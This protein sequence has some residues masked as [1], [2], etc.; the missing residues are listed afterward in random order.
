MIKSCS[1]L[2]D[3]TVVEADICII[4]GG[5]AGLTLAASLDG[6]PMRVAVIEAGG[7]PSAPLGLSESSVAAGQGNLEPPLRIPPR[8]GGGANE[9]IVRLANMQRGVRMLPLS[10][11][12]LESRPWIPHSGWPISWT[13]LDRYYRQANDFLGLSDRGYAAEDWE[14]ER[15]RRFALE[16]HGF[17]TTMEQFALPSVFTESIRQKLATSS[18]VEVYLDGAAGTIDGAA[19]RATHLAVDHGRAGRLRVH[20]DV[21]VLAAGGIDNATLL[22]RAREQMGFA[23][24]ADVVGRFYVDH[25][26]MITG[27]FTP[28]DPNLFRLAGLY[29]LTTRNETAVMGKLTPT[30]ELIASHQILHSGSMLLPKPSAEVEHGL[31]TIRALVARDRG[32]MDD[33]PTPAALARTALYVARTGAEMAIRQRRWPPR[34]DAGWSTLAG[35][36][37]ARF[38]LETQIEL[39]P[40][41]D[42]RVRLGDS[43]DRFGRRQ[44]EMSWSWNELDLHSLKTTSSL[45][46]TAFRESQ[47]GAFEP[48]SWDDQ[49]LLTTPN[50]AYH[51]S[52]TT[53]MGTSSATSVTD[54]DA[55]LHGVA[56]IYVAGSSVFP[57]VGYA[58]PTLTIVALALRLADHL[59]ARR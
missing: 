5:P 48:A 40:D 19:D 2:S 43:A 54:Q 21:F 29:D 10:P 23:D 4:G 50:G 49:P 45:L 24:S 6:A 52:G 13:E 57:T 37:F 1:G 41:R 33:R 58:N 16:A 11:V 17:T 46:E 22:L 3:D 53:R 27:S 36:P 7:E 20:A 38:S 56:N 26:R 9:W 32:A 47:L 39:T 34:V 25:Q 12:D 55:R 15:G 18:N 44:A 31:A 8:L 35:S 42:N 51:P 14:G 59:G 30:A 28:A